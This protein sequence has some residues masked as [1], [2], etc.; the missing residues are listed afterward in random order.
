MLVSRMSDRCPS[1]RGRGGAVF[2]DIIEHVPGA[3]VHD[4]LTHGVRYML[5][6]LQ[7]QFE[8]SQYA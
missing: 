1:R 8:H 7:M 6:L 4:Y 5:T 3:P 2:R